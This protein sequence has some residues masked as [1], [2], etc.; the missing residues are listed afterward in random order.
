MDRSWCAIVAVT[1][2]IARREGIGEK[3][4]D[5]V[6]IAVQRI[7]RGAEKFAVHIGG[8]ELGMHDPKFGNMVAAFARYQ[9]DATPGCHTAGFGP[10]SFI[11][12]VVNASGLCILGFG[13]KSGSEKMADFLNAVTDLNNTID[14]VLKAG[15]RIANIRHA[16][17]LSESISELQ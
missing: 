1:E 8:Q 4:A 17:N 3:L 12:N 16:F 14:D 11:G 7:G 15:E 9:L 6:K 10:G 13:M 2:K 5:G